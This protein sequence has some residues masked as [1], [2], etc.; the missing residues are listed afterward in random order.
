[1][2]K[3]S[4]KLD[5]ESSNDN[6]SKSSLSPIE[7]IGSK[8]N[9]IPKVLKKEKKK[10]KNKVEQFTPDGH[11]IDAFMQENRH[12]ELLLK[13][14]KRIFKKVEKFYFDVHWKDTLLLLT[15]LKDI[16]KHYKR[17]EELLFPLLQPEDFSQLFKNFEI[18]HKEVNKKIRSLI[19]SAKTRNLKSFQQIFNTTHEIIRDVIVK[20]EQ[21]LFPAALSQISEKQWRQ[22]REKGKEIGYAWITKR[23]DVLTEQMAKDGKNMEGFK[24]NSGYL[25][26][27]QIDVALNSLPLEITVVNG[28]DIITYYNNE[29]NRLF[30][31]EPAFIGEKFID[32]H[33]GRNEKTVKKIIS[34]FKQHKN[35]NIELYFNMDDKKIH[36][37][38]KPLYSPDEDYIGFIE[39][40]TDISYYRS[41]EGE[42]I[43]IGEE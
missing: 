42:K 8:S 13:E 30:K 26:L 15:E 38:Y 19:Q 35:E 25:T 6:Q 31:R 29:K 3:K 18:L 32:C 28:D 20:E 2:F 14:I 21:V 39:I 17:K 43:K 12:A 40:A 11:A 10:I 22:I 36:V 37:Q 23:E 33:T 27:N 7:E 5:L 41:I 9:K 16:E 34:D 24:L 4:K 1:M